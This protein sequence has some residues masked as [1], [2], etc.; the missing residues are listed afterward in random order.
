MFETEWLN[1]SNQILKLGFHLK[2][3]QLAKF[4]KYHQ[5]LLEWNQ[6][7]NLVSRKDT[8][9][10]ISFHFI[11]SLL[12]LNDIPP[13]SRVCDLGSGAGLPGI[14]IKIIRDDI[15]LYLIES[16][17]KKAN[18]LILCIERLNLKNA[19]VYAQRAENIT[20]LSFDIILI[21]L[22]GKIKKIV[23][24]ATPL[25]SPHGKIIFYKSK[26]AFGEVK[27]TESVLTQFSLK[28]KIK[29][30]VLPGTDIVRRLVYLE[31]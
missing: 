27:E 4:Q 18:F 16:I 20:E 26:T 2:I 31:Q 23:P 6:K 15:T 10:L 5:L 12:V 1:F 21:R 25:L 7:I 29:E 3:E 22:L 8:D 30:V 9:R 19:Q 14:P 24:I 28:S 17:R 13:N 11:D